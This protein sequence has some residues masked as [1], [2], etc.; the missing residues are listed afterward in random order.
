L[1]KTLG[2]TAPAVNVTTMLSPALTVLA[3]VRDTAVVVV[4]TD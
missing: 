1:I 3:D 4:P 2:F